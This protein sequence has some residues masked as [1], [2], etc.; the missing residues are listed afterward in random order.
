M[1][2]ELRDRQKVLPLLCLW[3][4]AP[5]GF[6]IENDEPGGRKGTRLNR[7]QLLLTGVGLVIVAIVLTSRPTCS[8]GCQT[9][10]EHLAAH[11]ID[12]LVAGPLG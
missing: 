5:G 7:N 8:A 3:T 2:S 1:K 4:G 11:G 10:A 12:D 6:R 9:V